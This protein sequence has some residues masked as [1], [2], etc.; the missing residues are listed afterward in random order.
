M[1]NQSKPYN[2]EGLKAKATA[3]N[4]D[5][6]QHLVG[7]EAY[8]L[9]DKEALIRDSDKLNSANDTMEPVYGL[10]TGQITDCLKEQEHTNINPAKVY[11]NITAND[12]PK[13]KPQISESLKHEEKTD[14][15]SKH[16]ANQE[17]KS[18]GNPMTALPF[19][20][21]N[22]KIEAANIISHSLGVAFSI[23]AT[24]N[25]LA[26][27]GVHARLGAKIA[28]F[29]YGISMLLM[30]LASSLYHAFSF[31]RL[32]P[33]FRHFDHSSIFLTI[34]GTYTPYCFIIL[35]SKKAGI[36]G[37][38]IWIIAVLGII[39]KNQK[40]RLPAAVSAMIYL[41]MGWLAVWDLPELWQVLSRGAFF[42]MLAGAIAYTLGTPF[43][44]YKTNSAMH[45]IWHL[46]VFTGAICFYF[47]IRC[48]LL[49]L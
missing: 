41:V 26:L 33:F 24:Q 28:I 19:T 1:K 7:S 45:I 34:A 18:I 4:A 23:Y 39:L 29:V 46:F 44:A 27:L 11:S 6:Q 38:L 32:R 12:M 37:M 31:S 3:L 20:A 10:T 40:M 48:A 36:L 8:A 43:Y 17:E 47:S 49:I 35:P 14:K 2:K 25:L 16:D 9:I 15:L 42:W 5:S 22:I 13:E 30:F 21:A